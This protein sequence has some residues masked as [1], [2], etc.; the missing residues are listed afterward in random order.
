MMAMTEA[1]GFALA[2]VM[3]WCSIREL[4]WSWP[5]AIASSVL[6]FFVF[7]DSVFANRVRLARC[8]GLA[9]VAETASAATLGG[10]P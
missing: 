5:L 2:V 6:Y 3:V 1:A 10:G 7:R 9:A 8:M 4:H